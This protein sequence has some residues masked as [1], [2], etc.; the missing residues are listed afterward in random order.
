MGNASLLLLR[1][2]FLFFAASMCP[3]AHAANWRKY[4]NCV[5]VFS[6]ALAFEHFWILYQKY[7]SGLEILDLS[8]CSRVSTPTVAT[9]D[10]INIQSESLFI[11]KWSC[12]HCL[13]CREYSLDTSMAI[14]SGGRFRSRIWW[15]R[16]SFGFDAIRIHIDVDVC[17]V[18]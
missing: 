1:F 17:I 2:S 11:W 3:F 4:T 18:V 9:T 13:H 8:R 14:S 15:S 5:G 10:I 12:K 6:L 16:I 7:F